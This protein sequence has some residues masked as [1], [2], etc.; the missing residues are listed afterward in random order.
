MATLRVYIPRPGNI[1]NAK[2][3]EWQGQLWEERC[4]HDLTRR[5]CSE[6]RILKAMARRNV[7]QCRIVSSRVDI[8]SK[9]LMSERNCLHLKDLCPSNGVARSPESSICPDSLGPK[10]ASSVGTKQEPPTDECVPICSFG[11]QYRGSGLAS[12]WGTLDARGCSRR[13]R[14]RPSHQKPPATAARS[15]T[16]SGIPR[17]RPNRMARSRD[18]WPEGACYPRGRCLVAAA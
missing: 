17:H 2:H 8:N 6:C 15:M 11:W 5:D 10:D 9:F 3:S 1:A 4:S 13:L 12:S 14:E 18:G 16:P 7:F